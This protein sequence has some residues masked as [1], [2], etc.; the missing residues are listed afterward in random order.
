MNQLKDCDIRN[1]SSVGMGRDHF[2]GILCSL[3]LGLGPRTSLLL[4]TYLLA[5]MLGVDDPLHWHLFHVQ[6]EMK[7]G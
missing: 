2:G 4:L 5:H 6:I 3:G 7:R 1:Q